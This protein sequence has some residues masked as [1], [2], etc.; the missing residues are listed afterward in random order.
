MQFSCA[1]IMASSVST[2]FICSYEKSVA[3]FVDT[4]FD[5]CLALAKEADSSIA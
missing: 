1:E 5:D 3:A 2:F 4:S